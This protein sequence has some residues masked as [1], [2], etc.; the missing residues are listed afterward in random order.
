MPHIKEM[1]VFFRFFNWN[2]CRYVW[3]LC[4]NLTCSSTCDLSMLVNDKSTQ[5]CC[6]KKVL[7]FNNPYYFQVLQ[8][9][10]LRLCW[11]LTVYGSAMFTGHVQYKVSGYFHPLPLPS[12]G[13]LSVHLSIHLFVW[14]L[15]LNVIIKS[16]PGDLMFLYRFVQCRRRLQTLFM[17]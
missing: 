10:F 12:E 8:M 15:K 3:I 14:N 6:L 5:T 13:V 4:M 17:R 11:N 16:P 1:M 7:S 2:F 9:E